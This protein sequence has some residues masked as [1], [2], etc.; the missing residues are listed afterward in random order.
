MVAGNRLSSLTSVD[1]LR[2]IQV[3]DIS[4]NQLD[5][6]SREYSLALPFVLEALAN[7]RR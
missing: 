4:R 6:V 5:S 7:G 2:N 3:L 1:H